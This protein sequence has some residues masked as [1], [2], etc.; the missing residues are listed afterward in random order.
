MAQPRE[1]REQRP[2]RGL[3][4][5]AFEENKRSAVNAPP[6]ADLKRRAAFVPEDLFRTG[7]QWIDCDWI[8]GAGRLSPLGGQIIAHRA[9]PADMRL[10][11]G[12]LAKSRQSHNLK[13]GTGAF[14][15]ESDV[16]PQADIPRKPAGPR[17]RLFRVLSYLP[18]RDLAC[19]DGAERLLLGVAGRWLNL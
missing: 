10:R 7:S 6:Y 1:Q 9:L 5:V 8:G 17:M 13:G 16:A 2:P 14:L 15:R 11:V 18:K 19:E 12:S 3:C 4:R